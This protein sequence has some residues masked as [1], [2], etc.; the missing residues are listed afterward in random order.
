MINGM[1]GAKKKRDVGG[2]KYTG[3]RGKKKGKQPLL[4]PAFDLHIIPDWNISRFD[5]FFNIF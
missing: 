5:I 4:F 1:S 2:K 3:C